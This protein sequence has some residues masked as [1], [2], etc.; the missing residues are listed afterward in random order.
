MYNLTKK[1]LRFEDE[2]CNVVYKMEFK[3]FNSNFQSKLRTYIK[4]IQKSK[5]VYIFAD[6]TSNVYKYRPEEYK[7]LLHDN[8]TKDYKKLQTIR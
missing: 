3:K 6:K 2:F 5:Y 1:L 8:I 7:K 4:T